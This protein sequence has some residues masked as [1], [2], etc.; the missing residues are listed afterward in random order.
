M[1]WKFE[2]GP[3][4]AQNRAKNVKKTRK[5]T[6]SQLNSIVITPKLIQTDFK[7]LEST[8]NSCR[9]LKS[10]ILVRSDPRSLTLLSHF[11]HTSRTPPCVYIL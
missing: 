7:S 3:E 2:T 5:I 11:F 9:M 4:I 6:Q 10:A 8:D 1:R